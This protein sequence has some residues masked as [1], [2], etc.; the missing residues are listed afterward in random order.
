MVNRAERPSR[1]KHLFLNRTLLCGLILALLPG[2]ALFSGRDTGASGTASSHVPV[3]MEGLPEDLRD[4]AEKA[5][6]IRTGETASLLEVRRRADQAAR[7]LEEYLASE[8]Y[9][10][11]QVQPDP[12]EDLAM[13]PRIDVDAGERFTIASVRVETGQDLDEDVRARLDEATDSLG[14]GTWAR[15]GDIEALETLLVRR[16]KESGYAFAESNGIDALASRADAT[17]E[18]TYALNPGPRVRLGQMNV[19]EG[20]RTREQAIEILRTW[21]PGDLYTPALMDRLRTRLRSTG[22]FDGI[23]AAIRETPESDGTHTVDLKLSEGKPRSVGAGISFSTTDGAGAEAFWER[24]NFTGWGDTVRLEALAATQESHVTAGYE[25]P[26]IG[27]YGRTL[28]AEA[29]IRNEETDAYD[30]QGIRVGAD[31]SQPFNKN[32]TLSAGAAI[33]AT[34]SLDLAARTA[35]TESYVELVTLSLPL[36]ATYDTVREPLDPQ[37]GNRVFLGVEPGISLGGGAASYTRIAGSASTYRRI[38]DGLVAA[39]RAEAGT[40]LGEDEVPADR[41]FFAGGGGSVRGYEYQSLSPSDA[42]GNVIG[43]DA[44]FNTSVELRWRKSDRWG[45]VAFVDAGAAA[46]NLG[47]AASDMRAAFGLGVRYFPGFGPIRFD[48]ATPIDR[49]DGEDPVQVYISI[50]QSF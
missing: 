5:V 1:T 8:G 48:I 15:T 22:L 36:G 9:F 38:A 14:I 46:A 32:F 4:G 21:Q 50:G 43:G 33:D 25:R 16:L 20:L 3:R 49:R 39:I 30:L 28:R 42:N 10:A 47:D 35:G 26:N 19:P 37:G 13:R 31:L 44:L 23:G 2:C 7:T 29:G 45:Y 6:A 40:F 41:K 17:V 12:V 18:L 34:R 11:A 27:R 24:R